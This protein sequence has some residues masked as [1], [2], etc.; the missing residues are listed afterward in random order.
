MPFDNRRTLLVWAGTANDERE[1]PMVGWLR[2]GSQA[3]KAT[4]R[5][6]ARWAA[7]RVLPN[8]CERRMTIGGSRL[9]TT[10]VFRRRE[11]INRV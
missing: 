2:Q 4:S 8:L 11:R 10:T 9:Q 6:S 1:R 7:I 3:A 5:R